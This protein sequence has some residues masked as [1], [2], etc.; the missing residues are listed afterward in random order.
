MNNYLFKTYIV[1][2]AVG[3]ILWFNLFY[4]RLFKAIFIEKNYKGAFKAFVSILVAA[5]LS[6]FWVVDWG[7]FEFEFIDDVILGRWLNVYSIRRTRQVR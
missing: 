2:V 3:L 6:W 5:A 4:K 7:L 1:G